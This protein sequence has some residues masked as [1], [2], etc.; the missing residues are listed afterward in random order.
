MLWLGGVGI[1]SGGGGSRCFCCG[2]DW[3]SEVLLCFLVVFWGYPWGCP[4]PYG[5]G[6]GGCGC[7]WCGGCELA[8]LGLGVL[9]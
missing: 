3:Y 9:V 1:V 4:P 6:G 2:V 5:G 7:G 8:L